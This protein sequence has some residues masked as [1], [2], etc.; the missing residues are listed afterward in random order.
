MR[1]ERYKTKIEI[2][3]EQRKLDL[4][5]IDGHILVAYVSIAICHRNNLDPC[6][7]LTL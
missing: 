2:E 7:D 6:Y 5:D 4:P 3:L 1:P